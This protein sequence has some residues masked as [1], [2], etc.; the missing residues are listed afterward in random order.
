[1]K[2][3]KNCG[4]TCRIKRG[5]KYCRVC[6]EIM[7]IFEVKENGR[8]V[9]WNL[10]KSYDEFAIF[11]AEQLEKKETRHFLIYH[12]FSKALPEMTAY[13]DGTFDCETINV[14]PKRLTS[15]LNFLKN[16]AQGRK[17]RRLR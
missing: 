17:T 10:L 8:L 14:Y 5:E 15:I 11:H 7:R 1:M 12:P 4:K 6:R 13:Y 16:R 2:I 3:C 9:E